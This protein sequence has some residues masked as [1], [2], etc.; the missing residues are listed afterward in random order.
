[1]KTNVIVND[2]ERHSQIIYINNFRAK[3]KPIYEFF[4]RIFDI[5]SSFAA[6]IVLMPVMICV[7]AVVFFQDFHNPFFVQTRMTK[8]GRTFRMF[9]FRSMCIDAESKLDALRSKNEID[10]PAFKM[11]NDP[12]ITKVGSF[13][14][15]TSLDELP[16]LFNI[17]TGSMSVVGPRPP[18]PSE[19]D[20]Y[21]PYQMQRLSVK[22][23][24]TCFWQC[25]GRS[26]VGFDEWVDMDLRYIRERSFFL[27]IKIIL[28]TVKSVLKRE[29]AK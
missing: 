28:K 16:Q 26:N 8:D 24:L 19:V 2:Y 20:E 15:K 18:I 6:I 9:K 29:G 23:G 21:T 17:L 4:K 1:M 13:I 10:G 25:S 7:A 5:L 22:S 3:H 11:E 12:R 14:R 27:D